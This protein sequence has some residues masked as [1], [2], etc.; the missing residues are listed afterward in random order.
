M[1][2][3]S[4]TQLPRAFHGGLLRRLRTSD[5]VAFQ[6]Y[7]SI[8]ELGR[9]QRWSPMSEAEALAFLAEMSEAPLF[10]L[11]DGVQLGIAEPEADQ[12]HWGHRHLSRNRWAHRRT[13]L[14]SCAVRQG[15][16]IA[17]AA[18]REALQVLLAS[19]A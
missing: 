16:G 5:L 2:T 3:Q 18:V 11:G 8:P 12:L 6:T 10:T 4:A 14:H 9:L 13:R 15:R 19:Q 1:H 17:T 7:R